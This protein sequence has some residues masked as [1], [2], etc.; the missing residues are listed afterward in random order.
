MIQWANAASVVVVELKS[1]K[2]KQACGLL[3]FIKSSSSL[4]VLRQE[5]YFQ[6]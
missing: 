6:I 3:H 2:R 1:T 4:F 5:T